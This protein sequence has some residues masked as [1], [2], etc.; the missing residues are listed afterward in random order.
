QASVRATQAANEAPDTPAIPVR[1]PFELTIE[2]EAPTEGQVETILEYAGEKNIAN[3]IEGANN[4][5]EALRRFQLNKDT[6]QRPMVGLRPFP[7]NST[8]PRL[9]EGFGVR[10]TEYKM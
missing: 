5:P 7:L 2:E 6:F 9:L 1:D 8:P 3:V 10:V 4:M